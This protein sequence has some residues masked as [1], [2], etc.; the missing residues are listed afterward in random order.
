MYSMQIIL[1]TTLIMYV[2]RDFNIDAKISF[3]KYFKGQS[4]PIPPALPSPK[5]KFILV[6]CESQLGL[7]LEGLY[8]TEN[9]F[10]TWGP[11]FLNLLKFILS[12]LKNVPSCQSLASFSVDFL[13]CTPTNLAIFICC[14]QPSDIGLQ[15]ITCK[16]PIKTP[17]FEHL[18]KACTF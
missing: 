5:K 6:Q 13:S 1:N 7:V 10:V 11:Q 15:Y 14:L 4:S 18:V 12:R 8:L 2:L 9:T 3:V 17:V 16:T